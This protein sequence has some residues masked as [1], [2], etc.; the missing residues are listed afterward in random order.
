MSALG[1]A[2]HDIGAGVQNRAQLLQEVRVS[3]LQVAAQILGQL[4]V[5]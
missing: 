3:P 1:E 4:L 2:E 5:L